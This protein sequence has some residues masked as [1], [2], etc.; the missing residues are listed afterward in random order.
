[1]E[2]SFLQIA[3]YDD[4]VGDVERRLTLVANNGDQTPAVDEREINVD[5]PRISY[6]STSLPTNNAE[7]F[8][9]SLEFTCNDDASGNAAIVTVYNE[10]L[11]TDF[12]V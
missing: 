8:V 7:R 12:N 1:M 5:L 6:D 2:L 10:E 11:D 3:D 9:Q 4:V